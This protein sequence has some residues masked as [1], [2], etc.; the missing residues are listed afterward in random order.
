M[1]APGEI[2]T[3]R[4]ASRRITIAYTSSGLQ[5]TISGQGIQRVAVHNIN[6]AASSRVAAAIT[7]AKP[8]RDFIIAER[9]VRP[10]V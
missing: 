6:Q 3:S 9:E 1:I 8:L 10:G 5:L 4:S 2:A 7:N